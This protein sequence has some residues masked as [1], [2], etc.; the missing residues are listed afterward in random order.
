MA[1][2]TNQ[3]SYGNNRIARLICLSARRGPIPRRKR[4]R[5]VKGHGLEIYSALLTGVRI[6]FGA[7]SA[8]GSFICVTFANGF[9]TSTVLVTRL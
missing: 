7:A 6:P 1:A 3:L 2:R 9:E 5:S 8:H 4:V